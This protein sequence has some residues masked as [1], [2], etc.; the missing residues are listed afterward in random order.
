MSCS[1]VELGTN[2]ARF[3][4]PESLISPLR[5]GPEFKFLFRSMEIAKQYQY[6]GLRFNSQLPCAVGLEVVFFESLFSQVQSKVRVLPEVGGLSLKGGWF[7]WSYMLGIHFR[8]CLGFSWDKSSAPPVVRVW[9]PY[10][11]GYFLQDLAAA[12]ATWQIHGLRTSSHKNKV[13]YCWTPERDRATR[14]Q[15]HRKQWKNFK[16]W[17]YDTIEKKWNKRAERWCRKR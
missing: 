13:G 17:K 1:S 6:Q 2:R 10:L 14:G 16:M 9:K 5:A 11:A 12:Q 15:R 4:F 8:G 7:I 3:Q